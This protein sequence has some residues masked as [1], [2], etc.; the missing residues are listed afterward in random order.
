MSFFRVS[1]IKSIW[2]SIK[3]KSKILIGRR[4]KV[5]LKKGSKINVKNGILKIGILHNSMNYTIIE[6]G[7]YGKMNINGDV[8]I[9][10]G[11]KIVIGN[12]AKLEINDKSYLNE[13]T[14]IVCLKNIHI[15]KECAISWG[16]NILDTDYHCLIKDGIIRDKIK[17]IYIDDFVWIGCNSTILKGT[18]L[19]KNTIIG[20]NS[21]INQIIDKN[22]LF[23]NGVVK[24]GYD[25]KL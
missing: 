9:G 12:S 11:C 10:I 17:E 19:S 4:C 25:W 18:Y 22:S 20:A 21:L 5:F 15:G 3:F 16:V 24:G 1:I 7:E 23:I 6:I 8:S 2:Y 14:K 13:D